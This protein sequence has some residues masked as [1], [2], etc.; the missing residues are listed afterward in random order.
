MTRLKTLTCTRL[1]CS[2][3][4]PAICASLTVEPGGV[5]SAVQ[6]L[7][8]DWITLVCVAV[9]LA[10]LTRASGGDVGVAIVELGTSVIEKI[11]QTWLVGLDK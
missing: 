9:A 10:T 7:P 5:V 3:A 4:K 2:I 6:T 1:C 8:C 11:Q